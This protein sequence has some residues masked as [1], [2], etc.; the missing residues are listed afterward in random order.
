MTSSGKAHLKPCA[1]R[2][3]VNGTNLGNVT[4][5]VL[6]ADDVGVF[7][8]PDDRRGIH[9]HCAQTHKNELD[10]DKMGRNL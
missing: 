7:R 8:K 2:L 9:V 5:A 10:H 3:V 4:A 6:K 1:T